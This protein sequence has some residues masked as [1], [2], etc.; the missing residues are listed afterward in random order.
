MKKHSERNHFFFS[1][2]YKLLFILK[3]IFINLWVCFLKHF[4][5]WTLP[6]KIF[7]YG[8]TIG[9]E[10]HV[11]SSS[12]GDCIKCLN[13]CHPWWP[14]YHYKGLWGSPF[15][16]HFKRILMY[17]RTCQINILYYNVIG[18]TWLE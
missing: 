16:H 9:W 3:L 17:Y 5:V 4:F 14:S 12:M 6:C 8:F 7:C 18:V 13:K 1:I 2:C 11:G 10:T 15:R